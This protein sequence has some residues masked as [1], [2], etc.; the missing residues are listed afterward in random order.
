MSLRG[1]L[2]LLLVYSLLLSCAIFALSFALHPSRD[3]ARVEKSI[4]S[5]WHRGQRMARAVVTAG[6]E[7]ALADDASQPD[8]TRVI[9]DVTGSAPILSL[10]PFLF[11]MSF[12]PGRDGVEASYQGRVA[13]ATPDDLIKR[14]AYDLAITVGKFK[15][16]FGV[17]PQRVFTFL[18]DELGVEVDALVRGGTFRRI[19]VRR[20]ESPRSFATTPENLEAAVIGAGR[21]LERAVGPDGKY[22]YETDGITGVDSEEYNLPRHSG[23]TWFLAEAAAFTRDRRMQRAARRAAGR[24]VEQYLKDCGEHRCIVEGP[25][26]DLGSSALALLAFT[27]LVES[28]IYPEL[29]DPMREL[30][31]FLRSQQR[32]DGEFKHLYDR[33]ARQ[34]IDV[35]LL[36]YTGEAAFALG[37]VHRITHDPRDIDAARRALGHLINTPFWYI[38]WR[39]YWNAEHWTCHAVDELWDRAPSPEALDFC[40][41]WQEAVRNTA[42][43]GRE[44]ARDYDGA[45][46]NGPFVPPQLVGTGTRM[47]AAASTLSAARKAKKPESELAALEGGMKA[48][49]AYLMRFQ[50]LPGPAHLMPRPELMLG[51][52]PTSDIDLRVRIDYPQHAGTGLLKYLKL[53]RQ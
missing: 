34:P 31:A 8:T 1:L 27:E 41:I 17:D 32:A 53:S 6:A 12:V 15:V 42:V 36:Y 39:Y 18:A 24:L 21:Y 50:L 38:G 29:E 9:E 40:L 45:S 26:A 44:A 23:A 46:T 51:G 43:S 49:L 2:R 3:P 37:R 52:I 4:V 28:G 20:R 30:A 33:A 16:K 35:Q 25:T 22:R 19:A 10:S 11:G 7:T 48:A 47:E 5:V 14:E 13:Y